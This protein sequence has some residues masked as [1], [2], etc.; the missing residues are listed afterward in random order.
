MSLSHTLHHLQSRSIQMAVQL[1]LQMIWRS[2]SENDTNGQDP[3]HEKE[4]TNSAA[5]LALSKTLQPLYPS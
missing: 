5:F 4:G 2:I 3:R 1:Y